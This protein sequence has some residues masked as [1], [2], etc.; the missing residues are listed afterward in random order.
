MA[1]KYPTEKRMTVFTSR[2]LDSRNALRLRSC[3]AFWRPGAAGAADAAPPFASPP[4]AAAGCWGSSN[5]APRC[6]ETSQSGARE[7]G[8]GCAHID[9]AVFFVVANG[10]G[11]CLATADDLLLQ[12]RRRDLEEDAQDGTA[13]L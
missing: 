2:C 7:P 10:L 8:E 4:A 13:P 6:E 3:A 12:H 1:R 5:W 11:D 9:R